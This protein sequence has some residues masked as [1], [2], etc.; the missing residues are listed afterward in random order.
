M[1]QQRFHLA[2]FSLFAI[3]VLSLSLLYTGISPVKAEDS[4]FFPE[5]GHTVSGKF[6]E[7]WNNN[8]GLATYGYP[9]TDAQMETDPETGKQFLTQWFERHRLEL[10][11]ENAGT[12]F[13][14]LAGLLGKDLRREA[15]VADPDFQKAEVLFNNAFSKD[16]QWYFPET[17]HN[18]RFRFLEYWQQNG[19]LERFG[20]PISEEHKEV[21]PET[22]NVFVMQWFER[23]RFEYHPENAGTPYDVLLG[24]LGKQI[25]TPKAGN[26]EFVWKI[27]GSYNGLKN[28]EG[29]AVD[30]QGNIFV[31]DT[32][33]HRIQKYDR[34]GTFLARWGGFGA[35]DGQFNYPKIAVDGHGNKIAVDGQ[36]NIFVADWGN[37]RIQKFDGNGKFLLKWGSSG[38]KD[39]Q[40]YYPVGIAVDG[41][42]NVY[43]AD[44]DNARIQKFDGN[45]KFLLKWGS[46][47]SKDG[48]FGYPAGIAVDGQGNVYVTDMQYQR[49]QKFDGNGK[50]LLKWGS[51]GYGDGQFIHAGSITV[52]GQGNVYFADW[53]IQKFDGNG[54]FLLKW[55]S[56]GYG[57]G[58]FSHPS[59]IA[60]AP[61]G[62]LYV[63]DNGNNRIQKFDGSGKFLLKWGSY[64]YGDGQFQSPNGI[65]VDGQGTLYVSDNDTNRIQ[66]FD[67]SG[68]FLLKW[69]SEGS[70]DGQFSG[71]SGIAVDGQGNVYV[72]DSNFYI[73]GEWNNRIQKFD[74]YGRFLLKWMAPGRNN[75]ALAV[76]G[77]GN[78]YVTDSE[79]QRIQKFDGNGKFLTNWGSKGNSD[80][81]FSDLTNSGIAVDG[82][83]NVFVAEYDNNRIQKFNEHGQFLLKWGSQGSGDGQFSHP[84]GI[85]VAPDGNLYVSDNGNNRIQYFDN[86]PNNRIQKFD[87]S[88]NFLLKWDNYGSGD[89]QLG[90][91]ILGV[92]V[93]W[94]GNVYV[95]VIDWG[96][97]R[98]QKFRQ[99]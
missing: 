53:R 17:G 68:K 10:H 82:Q 79:N 76:D 88:G 1:Q 49:I 40:F 7:Y 72:S 8:G 90:Y 47:G 54:T 66:K 91:N 78:V 57:D 15:L 38:S 34:N 45:G 24:L 96:N 98:I 52:D 43:V 36:G 80:G 64:G 12:K 28:P 51:N 60:V 21:D 2:R 31:A 35:G 25:K 65:A 39:G 44:T 42:G 48:Q 27:G 74:T 55:G 18:L 95:I 41:Q 70:G 93:D 20:Y 23:A 5:T 62:N 86:N 37:Q 50:F 97:Y 16:V 71:P 58:Q 87:G 30:G 32:G 19:G 26:V 6:L 92:A 46:S 33:N 85:A 63:S 89:G 94:Q 4:H 75:G 83:G 3:V 81:Q 29:V 61:D 56:Y 99:R 9:I 11:P 67:G 13:E 84:S 14:V 69:G 77:Q 22:G 59:G 73:A